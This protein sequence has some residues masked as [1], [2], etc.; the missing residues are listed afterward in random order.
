MRAIDLYERRAEVLALIN[1]KP[2]ATSNIARA[3]DQPVNAIVHDIS[4]MSQ[5]GWVVEDGK[6]EVEYKDCKKRYTAWRS[7]VALTEQELKRDAFGKEEVQ[8]PVPDLPESLLLMMGYTTRRQSKGR[9]ID[10]ADF[11][12]TPTRIAPIRVWPGTSWAQMESAL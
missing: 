9:F 1:K 4:I 11:H 12:P 10:N 6:D 3:L 5:R 2:M 7:L 8:V